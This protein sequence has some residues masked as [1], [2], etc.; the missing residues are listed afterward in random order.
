MKQDDK[1][2][3][4]GGA[5]TVSKKKY[6][7]RK[8]R[9]I[10]NNETFEDFFDGIK[11]QMATFYEKTYTDFVS[12]HIRH[13]DYYVY[14]HYVDNNIVYI[15]KGKDERLFS[16]N[17]TN[18]KHSDLVRDGK[19]ELVIISNNMTELNALLIERLLIAH[20]NPIFNAY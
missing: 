3:F 9:S 7:R 17:R 12:K 19:I 11:H 10:S 6:D 20:H 2:K 8:T 16:Y 1:R 13:G 5:S 4:N 15:G 18:S 14:A